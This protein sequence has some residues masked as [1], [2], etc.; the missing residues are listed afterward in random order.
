MSDA[1]D[2]LS[3]PA[4]RFSFCPNRQVDILL[5][6][7]LLLVATVF[8]L[9][10]WYAHPSGDDWAFAHDAETEPLL[11][12]LWNYY[13]HWQG[14]FLSST[15]LHTLYRIMTP[16]TASWV[17]PIMLQAGWFATFYA[18]CRIL[19]CPGRDRWT[20]F[21][22]AML[23]H[24][25]YLAGLSHPREAFYWVTGTVT[26][27][28]GLLLYAWAALLLFK[29]Q[30]SART[31]HLWAGGVLTVL[32]AT[33]CEIQAI[34]VL[35]TLFA[36]M[37]W[38]RYGNGRWDR[39]LIIIAI[40][41]VLGAIL[42][43][44]SPGN[45]AR[46]ASDARN[47]ALGI[48]DIPAGIGNTARLFLKWTLDPRLW[49]AT[50]LLAPLLISSVARHPRRN[51]PLWTGYLPFVLFAL[52][53]P[54]ILMV[55]FGYHRILVP[56]RVRN[57]LYAMYL[58]YW[59][60]ACAWWIVCLRSEWTA[61]ARLPGFLT[62]AAALVFMAAVALQGHFPRAARDLAV[63]AHAYDATCR[64]QYTRIRQAIAEHRDTA[65]I[66]QFINPPWTLRMFYLEEP[67]CNINT[68]MAVY[69]GIPRIAV[70]RMPVKDDFDPDGF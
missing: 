39:R 33:Y 57:A 1:P 15:V 9:I 35:G 62:T 70:D 16:M 45:F 11:P 30:M 19:L 60:C 52:L 4:G 65:I 5:K 54:G 59:F 51:W 64:E 44:A 31:S 36:F 42:L 48:G 21:W 68:E 10:S 63:R 38:T 8:L 34:A 47:Y 56:F 3:A 66:P 40:A 37:A 43:V 14:R 67:E 12:W 25:L 49:A 18:G 6:A 23:L 46:A 50:I 27:Q 41:S 7:L 24:V 32:A 55:Y 69:F 28:I 53:L 13:L 17:M 20:A 26:Y 61:P 22:A 58:I 2:S 29:W